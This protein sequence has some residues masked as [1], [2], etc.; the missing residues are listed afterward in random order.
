MRRHMRCV[1]PYLL[2]RACSTIEI[3]HGADFTSFDV[4]KDNVLGEDNIMFNGMDGNMINAFVKVAY[5]H[6]V[7]VFFYETESSFDSCS[8]WL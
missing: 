4:T 6:T 5:F 2:I 8:K 7:S 3:Q 1:E